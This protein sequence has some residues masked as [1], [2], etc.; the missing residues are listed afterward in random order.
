MSTHCWVTQQRL[1]NPLLSTDRIRYATIGEAVFSPCRA[2]PSRTAPRSLPCNR[3]RNN[4]MTVARISLTQL[5][6][7]ATVFGVS[8]QRSYPEGHRRYGVSF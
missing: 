8:V 6:Y 4:T 3:Q 2:E 5:N 7:L 1:R